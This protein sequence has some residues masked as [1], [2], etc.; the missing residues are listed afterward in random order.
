MVNFSVSSVSILVSEYCF[1]FFSVLT[2]FIG[3]LFSPVS[4]SSRFAWSLILLSSI[5]TIINYT[6]VLNFNLKLNNCHYLYDAGLVQ[7]FNILYIKTV[8]QTFLIIK[9]N[10][11][12]KNLLKNIC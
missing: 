6:I 1:L 10:F 8:K 7:N 3:L 9:F 4:Y 5:F 11:I 2:F 12:Y